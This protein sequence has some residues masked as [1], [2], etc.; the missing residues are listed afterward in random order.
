MRS[1]LLTKKNHFILAVVT[2]SPNNSVNH[3]CV[4]SVVL[5]LTTLPQSIH[6]NNKNAS[7]SDYFKEKNLKQNTLVYMTRPL[8]LQKTLLSFIVMRSPI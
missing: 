5:S 2:Y 6:F 8:R 1:A 7:V 3:M 4:W